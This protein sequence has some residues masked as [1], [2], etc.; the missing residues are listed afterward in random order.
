MISHRLQSAPITGYYQ[1]LSQSRHRV[2]VAPY[3]RADSKETTTKTTITITTT[4]ASPVAEVMNDNSRISAIDSS[5]ID[6]IQQ[7]LSHIRDKDV[8]KWSS[9]D[10][11]QWIEEQCQ[12]FELKKATKEKF[13]MNGQALV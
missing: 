4:T 8:P 1:Y 12:Q 7:S 3:T 2:N 11:Q 13:Q 5:S 10:V 9:I 6:T